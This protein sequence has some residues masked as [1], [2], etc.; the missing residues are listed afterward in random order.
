MIRSNLDV[1]VPVL[2][3]KWDEVC[4]PYRGELP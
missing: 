3:G 2:P 4:G 1:H